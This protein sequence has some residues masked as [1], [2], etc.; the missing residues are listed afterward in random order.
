MLLVFG[1]L[2]AV[3]V[4]FPWLE[5]LPLGFALLLLWQRYGRR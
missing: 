3:V 1:L 4:G 2:A 5:A